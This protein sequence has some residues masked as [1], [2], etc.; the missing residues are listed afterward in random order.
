MKKDT[1]GCAT[2]DCC[3]PCCAAVWAYLMAAY[4]TLDFT[5][6]GVDTVFVTASPAVQTKTLVAT[7]TLF[8][9]T[10]YVCLDGTG[11]GEGPYYFDN[12]SLPVTDGDYYAPADPRRIGRRG[13]VDPNTGLYYYTYSGGGSAIQA[14]VCEPTPTIRI[15]VSCFYSVYYGTSPV[16]AI[17]GAGFVLDPTWGGTGDRYKKVV[18]D[19]THFVTQDDFDT[20]VWHI[21]SSYD[22]TV[23]GA[24]NLMSGFPSTINV[25]PAW[26]PFG[27][28]S[29]LVM[30]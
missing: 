22:K 6:T 3:G 17:T 2:V 24:A 20:H 7:Y 29:E 12:P 21:D 14:T 16:S 8:G 26:N 1:P 4:T 13:T 25:T 19:I 30:S 11:L 5:L 28:S 27:M 10:Q 15:T 18:G 23:V 9:V